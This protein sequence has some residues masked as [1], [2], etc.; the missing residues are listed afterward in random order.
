[1]YCDAIFSHIIRQPLKKR[2]EEKKWTGQ[3]KIIINERTVDGK[4]GILFHTMKK[5]KQSTNNSMLVT[6]QK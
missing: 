6:I 4:Q 5:E 1:M 2:K 3:G